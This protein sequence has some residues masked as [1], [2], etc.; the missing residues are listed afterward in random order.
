MPQPI[1]E[2]H[3]MSEEHEKGSEGM[4]RQEIKKILETHLQ[5]LS[6]ISEED[7]INDPILLCL[8]TE[9]LKVTSLTLLFFDKV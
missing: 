4:E 9:S 7:M 3:P 2:W 8:V 6:K 1:K 5:M